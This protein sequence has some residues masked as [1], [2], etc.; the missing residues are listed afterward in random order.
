MFHNG[1]KSSR[2]FVSLINRARR[3]ET[4]SGKTTISDFSSAN[5]HTRHR[6]GS[7]AKRPGIPT[8]DSGKRTKKTQTTERT[9]SRALR[10][11]LSNHCAGQAAPAGKV[12]SVFFVFFPCPGLLR[13]QVGA[14]A[15]RD[16]G[17]RHL[18]LAHKKT[19]RGTYL[20]PV[21]AMTECGGQMPRSIMASAT[22]RK[23][24]MLAPMT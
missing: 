1:T 18:L 23:P 16:F 4:A 12:L 10:A 19:G 21:G 22:L 11:G 20:S 7:R 6:E 2:A 8:C 3:G 15:Q 5:S 13:G 17:R 9:R 14:S 24:A